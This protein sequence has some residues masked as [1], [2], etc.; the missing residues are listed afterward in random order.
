[1]ISIIIPCYNQGAY[2]QEAIDS[3][4]LQTY[5]D[6][7]III[8][9]DGS[10]DEETLQELKHFKETGII[11]IETTNKGVSAA[12][13][14][15]I[16]NAKGEFIL[17]LDADD[18]IAPEY[19]EEAIR[20][21]HEKAE[22]KLVYCNCEYFGTKKGLS[23]VP[24]FSLEGMLYENLIFNAALLRKADVLKAGGYDESF[25]TGWEDW[26]FWLRYIKKEEEV[27]K[28]PSVHF[29][30]RIKEDSRNS[31]LINDRLEF[32]EKQLFKK[33][34]DLYFKFIKQ[35]I[36]LFRNYD[37]FDEELKKLEIYKNQ[38]HQSYSYRLGNT[39]LYPIKWLSRII[40][41]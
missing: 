13:N 33:H 28:I 31:L 32:C 35:P 20:I 18:K 23:L 40:K 21:M 26:E 9:D 4:K 11:V 12:R 6:W 41:K 25:L 16:E 5:T 39:I 19:L 29:F 34:I 15:G 2:L 10:N 14:K 24:S 37:F 1:M 17:P 3:V 27:Y 30:Y 8:V 38:L 36:S 7:E 22:V